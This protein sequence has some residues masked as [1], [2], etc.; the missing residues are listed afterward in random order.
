[1]VCDSGFEDVIYS[2]NVCSSG[3]L[4]GVLAGSHYNRA[5]FVH[6]NFSEVLE[7]LLLTRFLVE[8][9]PNIPVA[10]RSLDLKSDKM[11]ASLAKDFDE[12]FTNYE[13]FR[14]DVRGGKIGRT[15]QFWTLYL[16]LMRHQTMAHTAVQENDIKSLMFCWKQYLPLYFALNKLHYAR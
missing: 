13:S 9:K 2:S 10:L 12:L 8:E 15:A 5:W 11:S 7:R 16:D 1:M 3:S 6:G 4:Q 14:S